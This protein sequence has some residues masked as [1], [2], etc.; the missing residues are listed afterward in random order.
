M[1]R[2]DFIRLS[3]FASAAISVPLLHSCNRPVPGDAIAK[4]VFL[5]RLFDANTINEAGK[6]YLKK[7]AGE[8]DE[9]KLIQLLSDNS[10]IA[11]SKDEKAVH[12]FLD[13]KVKQDFESGNTVLIKGWVLAVTE[14]RQCALYSLV[15]NN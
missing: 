2:R 7:A 1:K 10:S 13:K 4:P 3:A 15:H 5:S 12:E 9:D 8:N 11:E 6:D 14:A